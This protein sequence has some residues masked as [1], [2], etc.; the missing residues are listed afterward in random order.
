EGL[1][2][3]VTKLRNNELSP[4]AFVREVLESSEFSA[5][6]PYRGFY[7]YALQPQRLGMDAGAADY[8]R[9][10][11][12][13]LLEREADPDELEPWLAKLRRQETNAYQLVGQL[14]DSNEFQDGRLAKEFYLSL[15]RG[16]MQAVKQL[17]KA[18]TILDLGGGSGTPEGALL[19]MGYPYS[20][21]KLTIIEMP[22]ENRHE[23]YGDLGF[24]RE[25][26]QSRQ[27]PIH[28]V[29]ASM[30]DLAGFGD[31]TLELVFSGETLEHI[32]R[33][34]GDHVCREAYRVLKPGGYF[35]LDT[36]NRAVTKLH[37]PDSW[38]HPEHQHEYTHAELAGLLQKHGFLIRD[39]KGIA[40]AQES[41]ASGIFSQEECIRHEGLYDDIEKCYLLNYR[42]QKPG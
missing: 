4:G 10:V 37:F 20:F 5:Q 22:P 17:P 1:N 13:T 26:V 25:V 16:R 40:L 34:D 35:C 3:W 24:F 36:P 27:G 21:D 41:V 29:Y 9:L 6:P 39:A 7:Q 19:G 12:Q 30:T 23:I 38:I 2:T 14:L 33:A 28:W 32:T 11:F 42:C 8:V 18:R 15:H 31:E